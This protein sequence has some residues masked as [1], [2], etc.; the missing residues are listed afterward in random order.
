MVVGKSFPNID[1]VEKVRGRARYAG[2]ISLP[3]ML[4][5]RVFRSQHPHALIKE[6]D[7]SRALGLPGVRWVITASDCQENNHPYGYPRADE[8]I[9]APEK[10]RFAGDEI[11]LVVADTPEA[12]A[13]A[14]DLVKVDYN[15]LPF[16]LEPVE[17]LKA[18]A[19]QVNGKKNL[20]HSI[21][22]SRGDVDRAFVEADYV[23][24]H[25]YA[26]GFAYQA[27]MEPTSAVAELV[28]DRIVIYTGIQDPV[29]ARFLFAQALGISPDCIRIIQTHVGGGFGGKLVPKVPLL[30]AL[31]ALCT[32]KSVKLINPRHEDFA[33]GQPRVG[34]K[35][36]LKL[37][38]KKDGR[39]IAKETDIVADNGAYTRKGMGVLLSA[40]QRVDILYRIPNLRVRADL[41]YTNKAPTG[42]FRGFGNP[43]MHFAMES[44]MDIVAEA[45]E[46]DPI[47]LR[48]KN[49]AGEGYV[50]PW[51]LRV[52]S[53]GLEECIRQVT[54]ASN[55][56][57]RS[58]Q[59][60]L[61]V[62]MGAALAVHI[63]GN[64][65]A[66]KDFD[67]SAAMVR[68][69]R[70][71]QVVVFNGEADM[72]QGWRT[73][74]AQ[75]AAE[76][77]G[78]PVG[79]VQVSMI[80][81]DTAP[82]GWGTF[83]SRVTYLGGNAVKEACQKA[84]EILLE[85]AGREAGLPGERLESREGCILSTGGSGKE[86]KTDW[87]S[88]VRRYV[89][90]NGGM[91]LVATGFFIPD[92]E[93]PDATGQGNISGAYSFGAVVA[94]VQVDRETGQVAVNKLYSA[95]DL[96]KAINPMLA[97]G[98]IEGGAVMGVGLALFEQ[99][100]YGPDG[101]LINGGFL[102]YRIPTVMETP[103][104]MT[105]LVESEEATGPY[106]AKGIGEVTTVPLMPAI[107]NAVYQA[108][109]RRLLEMPVRPEALMG[110]GKQ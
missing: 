45:L 106:G 62:G 61:D 105:F 97:E 23:F 78:I 46:M 14:L 29:G 48:R 79:K 96:G 86:Y 69:D 35:I 8:Y 99:L 68:I 71:G 44:E 42:A 52:G 36:R 43:Q 19:P 1:S 4:Y 2:D 65:A 41:V 109:G 16:V 39:I 20:A 70:S 101:R 56:E 84:R 15:P 82:F 50:A 110:S 33:A 9:L 40:T 49:I 11:A 57:V 32:G 98:Q 92:T 25:Q 3:G 73:V 103:E 53:C 87:D 26:L 10:A 102:D 108:T 51:G 107:A 77:L 93:F 22:R 100:D 54:E 28:G 72:G 64:R 7:K 59:K 63:S 18:G 83:A 38:V 80:D 27:Y 47:E 37:G 95:F 67:G 89:N 31:A 85:F 60:G 88:L 74:T 90:G 6:I 58:R 30:C 81:T 5:G 13:E 75:I 21:E 12:A 94:E 104:I 34:M 24:E 17:A 55:W 91:P 66:K 76:T